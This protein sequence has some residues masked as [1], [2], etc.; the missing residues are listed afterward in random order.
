MNILLL[1]YQGDMAGSTNSIYY[2]ASGL[3]K[4]GH[5]VVVGLRRES[6]LYRLLQNTPLVICEPMTFGGKLDRENMRQIRDV[7]KRYEIKIINAQSSRDRYT[8][9]FANWYYGMQ[10]VVVHTRRQKP[11][12]MGGFLQRYLYIKGTRSIITVSQ[13]LKNTFV[14]QG[15]PTAH[16][17]V[18]YNG[19]PPQHFAAL[20]DL[21][22]AQLR[23]QFGFTSQDVVIGCVSRP[24]SQ[25]QLIAALPLL[26]LSVKVLF[27]G[28]EPNSLA[29]IARKYGVESQV[30]YAGKVSPEEVLNYYKLFSLKVLPSTMDGFGLVLLEAMGLGVPVVATRSE[31]LIDVL[32]NEQN[33]LWFEDGDIVQLAEKIKI[34]LYDNVRRQE[35]IENGYRAA[36]ET[37]SLEKTLDNYEAFFAELL[38]GSK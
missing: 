9:I 25:A 10:V 23:Q 30:L 18:I 4:R 22:V 5:L 13:E 35:L 28:I 20:N 7:V 11:K 36:H 38:V 14:R 26:P 27:V 24:K 6:L 12:S 8:S 32:A 31:G 1:T 21:R 16:I 17:K 37:F 2:L 3:A 33:G 29:D 15:Y 34:A 19:L